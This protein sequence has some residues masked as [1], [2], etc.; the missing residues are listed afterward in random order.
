MTS[1]S[2]DKYPCSTSRTGC[3]PTAIN[4][5]NQS[6]VT[7]PFLRFWVWSRYCDQYWSRK[8]STRSDGCGRCLATNDGHPS[9]WRHPHVRASQMLTRSEQASRGWAAGIT[10]TARILLGFDASRLISACGGSRVSWHPH[11]LSGCCSDIFFDPNWSQYRDHT[12]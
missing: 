3:F 12:L 6:V 7:L 11:V 2:L 10:D 9:S 8:M 4:V 5:A 1:T